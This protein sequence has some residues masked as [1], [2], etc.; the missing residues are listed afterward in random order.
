MLNMMTGSRSA[1]LIVDVQ[2]DFCRGG[3]LEVPNGDSVV[4]PLR[5]YAA[6]AVARGWPVYGVRIP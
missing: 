4:A 2:K 1:L 5:R 3:A 6:E